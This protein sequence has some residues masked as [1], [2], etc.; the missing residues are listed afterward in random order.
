[1]SATTG[2]QLKL[3][4]Q[5]RAY[6]E[7]YIRTLDDRPVFPSPEAL[8]ALDQFDEPLPD[9]SS[10]PAD[11]L[12]ML[13]RV[14][15]PGT[16]AQTGGR[17]FGF[18]NGGSLPIGLAARW[19]ADTWDQNTAH[20]VMS[21]VASRLEEVCERWLVDLFQLPLGTAAGFV[22]GTTL[23]NFS[24]LAA[25]RN[26]LLRR[27]GWSVAEKGLYG[28]P[29]LRVIV[30]ADAHAAV[31][32][33]LMLLGMGDAHTETVPVDG[34]GRMRVDRLPRL[35]SPTLVVAQAGNVNSGGFDPV[36]EICN[37]AHSAD[38]WVHVDGAFGLW[39][40]AS[41][42][43]ALLYQGAEKAD[44]WAVDA[45]KTLNVP[46]DCG[47]VLCR[48][49]DALVSAFRTSAAYF[50]W[51]SHR[52][53]MNYTPSMSK[54]ARAVELWAILK[55]L[56]RSGVAQLV[57]RLCAN[58]Q[59]FAERLVNEGFQ[60]HNDV[61][62]NQ[63]LASGVDDEETSATLEGVQ[64]SGECWCGGSTWNGRAVIRV[65]VCSWATTREDVERSVAAFVAARSAARRQATGNRNTT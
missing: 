23:A 21:P 54:R 20:H 61:V 15:S 49:R 18:V 33:S 5:A 62:F 48:E 43:H 60:I 58:A 9:D 42:S 32:K 16:V 36:G 59:Y 12:E 64:A 22:T 55:T 35:D 3:L 46:Y 30:G 29:P 1:M 13:D 50:Q 41:P 11:T 53:P 63:V 4:D 28:A 52:D 47:I 2:E 37:V 31:Q 38:G 56:G 10:D 39:A 6:A 24:G 65:S 40:G 27:R 51:S 7:Q 57:E 34:Q 45:H 14:G 26:E 19:L 8:E 17:Y 25:G 44:S